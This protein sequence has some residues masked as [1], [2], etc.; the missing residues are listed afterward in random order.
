MTDPLIDYRARLLERLESVVRDLADAVA[1]IPADRW[2]EP[3]RAGARSPHAIVAHLRDVERYAYLNR[4]QRLIAEESPTFDS[5]DPA[6]W[7]ND[8]YNPAESMTSILADYAGLRETELQILRSL[9]P[10]GW[11]RSARHATLGQRTV[12]WW[13][14][15]M[16]DNAEGRLRE[17]RDA[18]S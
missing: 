5:F 8:H 11:A 16:L 10:A 3:V 1:A 14:E 13:A 2:P 6:N 4:L 15:C 12:Q 18:Q 9:S 17:L 7:E